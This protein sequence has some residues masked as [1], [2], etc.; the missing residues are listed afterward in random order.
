[1]SEESVETT[2]TKDSTSQM[3]L[4]T[5]HPIMSE[6]EKMTFTDETLTLFLSSLKSNVVFDSEFIS[7]IVTTLVRKVVSV[8]C[9]SFLKIYTLY[10][11]WIT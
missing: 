3:A 11:I 5:I 10:S 4:S 6:R 7:E 8:Q 9:Q 2:R 1:M